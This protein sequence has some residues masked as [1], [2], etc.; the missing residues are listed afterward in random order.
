MESFN[1]EPITPSL[2][3]KTITFKEGENLYKCQIQIIKHFLEVT[4]YLEDKLRFEGNEPLSKIQNQ[5]HALIDYNI[6]EIFEEINSLNDNNFKIIKES[7][8]FQLKIEFN[9]LKRKKYL[10]IDLYEHENLENN[11]LIKNISE[12]KEIIKEKDKK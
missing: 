2:D 7:N 6:N 8:K 12:L 1:I 11:D 4:L 5:I 9:I 10:I 3:I